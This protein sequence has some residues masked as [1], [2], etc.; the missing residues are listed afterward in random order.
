MTDTGAHQGVRSLLARFENSQNKTPSPPSRGRSPVNSD[1]LSKV[2]ASFIAVDGGTPSN[3]IIG[4]KRISGT[5]DSPPPSAKGPRSLNSDDLDGS[6]K[7]VASSIQTTNSLGTTQKMSGQTGKETSTE[8]T[9][10]STAHTSSEQPTPFANKESQPAPK[11]SSPPTPALSSPKPTKAVSK[12]PPAVL[13]KTLSASKPAAPA[14]K[15]PAQP[16]TPTSPTKPGTEKAARAT[17]TRA[18]RPS[19]SKTNT[20]SPKAPA[21][22]PSR[23]S[24]NT[25]VKAAARPARAST[26][27]RETAKSTHRPSDVRSGSLPRQAR[28]P[29]S[30]TAPSLAPAAKVGPT[31]T[32]S[33]KPSTLRNAGSAA[34]RAVT[35]TAASVRKQATRTSPGHAGN[36]RPHSRT[37]NSSTKPV[38]EGFLARM[39]RPTASSANKAHEKL[40]IRS[41]P[42]P[43][44]ARAPRRVPSR[45]ETRSTRP[46]K[47]DQSVAEKSQEKPS[48]AEQVVAPELE[49]KHPNVAPVQETTVPETSEETATGLDKSP[50][51]VVSVDSHEDTPAAPPVEPSV[52]VSTEPIPELS[53][54]AE[55]LT[56][57]LADQMPANQL[58]VTPL[59]SQ[60]QVNEPA[61]QLEAPVESLP[62]EAEKFTPAPIETTVHESGQAESDIAPVVPEE[63][64]AQVSTDAVSEAAPEATP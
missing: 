37:S 23:A 25:T 43:Q 59:E 36:D 64:E 50:E 58:E 14:P 16:R 11:L 24:L 28:P 45:L 40:E 57:K 52:E 9:E 56:S 3:P 46:V 33:R 42:R 18:P 13:A 12:K 62:E 4:L 60:T 27:A 7:S 26:P 6:V 51:S 30:S 54:P 29:A 10:P 47:E 39:M 53:E 2:R 38:D 48:A 15:S 35:P 31:S 34:Q 19:T 44:V 55:A 17:A 41:P 22:K 5:S 32:L 21:H 63:K 8:V 61:E 49:E 20:D 1:N